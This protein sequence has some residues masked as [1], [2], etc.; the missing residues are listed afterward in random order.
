M[1]D[2]VKNFL[3]KIEQ[4]KDDKIKVD[5]LSTGKKIDSESLTFKQQKDIIS[6]ITD[7][8]VGP[9][10]FQKNLNDI[11]IENTN[12]KDLKI[13]DKLLI[14]IQLRIDS[15]GS[16]IKISNKQYDVL[17]GVVE[18]L[19]KIKHTLSKKITGGIEIDLEVPTLTAEN[20]VISTCV[21]VLKKEADKDVG[22]SL[23]EIYTYELVKYIKSLTVGEDTVQFS[24]ISVRDRIKIVNN[25][26]L[27]INKQIIEFIQD[28][29]QKEVEVLKVEIDG[30]VHQIDIDVAFFDA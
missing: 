25:L 29:K 18:Q 4:L 26:P 30:E 13:I 7:G 22:K 28:I 9:L 24:E 2:N 17:N 14:V 19:K 21:D 10:K 27:S 12:N 16:F 6:T 1:D 5:V 8:I 23:S 3:D 11:I 15:M 20:Q